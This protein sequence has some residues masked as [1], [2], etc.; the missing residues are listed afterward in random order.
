[1]AQKIIYTCDKCGAEC[2]GVTI[3]DLGN[4][5]VPRD[6]EFPLPKQRLAFEICSTCWL[7]L[8]NWFKPKDTP[9]GAG[10]LL[11]VTATKRSMERRP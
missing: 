5:T 7:A 9:L 11:T 10:D 1:M 8:K 6:A 3:V 4:Y 2:R